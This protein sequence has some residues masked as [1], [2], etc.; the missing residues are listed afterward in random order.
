MLK[1]QTEFTSVNALLQ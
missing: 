1:M